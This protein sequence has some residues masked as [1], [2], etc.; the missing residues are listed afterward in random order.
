[1]LDSSGISLI[2]KGIA[3]STKFSFFSLGLVLGFLSFIGFSEFN[4]DFI[5]SSSCSF[6]LKSFEKKSKILFSLL[7]SSTLISLRCKSEL[8]VFF[9]LL[10]FSLKVAVFS[11]FSFSCCFFLVKMGFYSFSG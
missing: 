8:A 10:W 9:T 7:S 4:S 5:F 2:S 11:F 6:G 3:F 1:M